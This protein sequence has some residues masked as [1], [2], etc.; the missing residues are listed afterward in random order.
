MWSLL[1]SVLV[2]FALVPFAGG[3]GA[4]GS[5]DQE[6]AIGDPVSND[7]SEPV[8]VIIPVQNPLP[9]GASTN[10]SN[11]T[12]AGPVEIDVL[13]RLLVDAGLLH[14]LDGGSV[15]S[16][17]ASLPYLERLCRELDIPDHRCRQ[18]YGE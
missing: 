16:P 13:L 9:D 5:S 8:P 4:A 1:K 12:L 10:S 17:A 11:L 15:G 2:V 18:L 7:Q 6:D 14:S 3:C